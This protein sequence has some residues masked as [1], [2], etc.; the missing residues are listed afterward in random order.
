MVT[1]EVR[2]AFYIKQKEPNIHSFEVGKGRESEIVN[3]I[4]KIPSNMLVRHFLIS[5]IRTKS[6]NVGDF[7]TTT[8]IRLKN[9]T[10]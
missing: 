9:F 4:E 10:V 8:K 5:L 7:S 6:A 3:R 2:D 1:F